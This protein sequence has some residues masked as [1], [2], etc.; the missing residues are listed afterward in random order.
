MGRHSPREVCLFESP[1]Q[2]EYRLNVTRVLDI[3]GTDAEDLTRAE[4]EGLRQAHKVF[5]FLKKYAPGF[6]NAVFMDTAE[7]IGIRETRHIDGMRR[8]TVDDVKICAV[9]VDTIA[10]MATNMDTHNK[11]DP[12]R[13]LLYAHGGAVFRRSLR[14]SGAQGASLICWWPGAHCPQTPWQGPPHA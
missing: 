1:Q 11:S 3:D 5:D 6:E 9:P 10:V 12:G 14:L 8:L 13:Y 2:G 4:V 7:T